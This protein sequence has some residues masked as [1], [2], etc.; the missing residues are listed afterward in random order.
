MPDEILADFSVPWCKSLY[1]DPTLQPIATAS[2]IYH[3]S[4]GENSLLASTLATSACIRAVQTFIRRG[5]TSLGQTEIYMLFSLGRGVEGIAGTGHG[6]IVALVLDEVMGT[7]AAEVFGR[8]GII[9][10]ALEVRF[11]RRLETP[12]VVLAK[13]ALE[14]G[15]KGVAG[16]ERRKKVEILGT[17]EDGEGGLLAEGKTVFVRLRPRL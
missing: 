4:T 11:K 3:P 8:Y 13:A 12:R 14:G 5:P 16:E 1:D 17:V 2:R 10:A 15:K 9:T 7:L 6:A